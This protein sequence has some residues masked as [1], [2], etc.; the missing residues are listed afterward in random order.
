MLTAGVVGCTVADPEVA[1]VVPQDIPEKT[2]AATRQI[3]IGRFRIG[4]A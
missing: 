1:D 2:D 4:I 3:K